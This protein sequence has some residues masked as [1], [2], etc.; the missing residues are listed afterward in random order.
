[1]L[2]NPGDKDQFSLPA[3]DVL[4]I[5]PCEKGVLFQFNTNFLAI[6]F[7]DRNGCIQFDGMSRIGKK[8]E[9]PRPGNAAL[10]IP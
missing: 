6:P 9:S 10:L 4:D 2:V 5:V 7:G 8:R 3:I 1:L